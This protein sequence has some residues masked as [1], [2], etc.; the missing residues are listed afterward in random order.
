VVKAPEKSQQPLRRNW[1]GEGDTEIDG[2]GRW[3][4]RT[5]KKTCD[6][7]LKGGGGGQPNG[8]GVHGG[9]EKPIQMGDRRPPHP[10]GLN[11]ERGNP[12]FLRRW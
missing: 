8:E 9:E 11:S 5:L 7:G 1:S 6:C 12:I 2:F 3:P 10:G 4:E